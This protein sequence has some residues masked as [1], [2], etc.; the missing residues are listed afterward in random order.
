MMRTSSRLMAKHLVAR[1]SIREWRRLRPK[2]TPE[3]RLMRTPRHLR[4]EQL[5]VEEFLALMLNS[6]PTMSNEARI[7]LCIDMYVGLYACLCM[8]ARRHVF[9]PH[10]V[11]RN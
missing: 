8:W 1:K 7:M 5:E 9:V 10:V 11:S 2:Q 6:A 4:A 3:R